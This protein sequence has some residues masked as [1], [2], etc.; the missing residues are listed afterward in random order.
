M[1]TTRDIV[2]KLLYTQIGQKIISSIFG[3]A[4]ALLFHRT[5]KDNCVKFFAPHVKD[6]EGNTFRL[7]ETCFQYTP[8]IVDC[9]NTEVLFP[10]DVRNIP[11]NKLE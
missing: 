8:Y 4:I 3:L 5:C 11:E 9:S 10:Y 7:D 1:N 6:I 2:D